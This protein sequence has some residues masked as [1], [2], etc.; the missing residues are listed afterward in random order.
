MNSSPK[1]NTFLGVFTPS[2]LTILGVILYLRVGWVVGNAGLLP[3]LAIIGLANIISLVT[4]LSVSAVSTNMSVG[5]GGAYYIVSRSLG[6]EIG[7]AIGI[8]LYLSQV[9]SVTLYSFGFAES[10]RIL[11]PELPI[12]IVAAIVVLAVTL[13]SVK[14]AELSLK[15]QIPVMVFIALSFISLFAGA[16]FEVGSAVLWGGYETGI[17]FWTVFAVFFPAVTGILVGVSMSGD[18]KNPQKSIPAGTLLAVI[19]GF[20]FYL[21]VP[22]ALAFSADKTTLLEDS[23]VWTKVAIVPF[24]VLPGLWGAIFSSAVGSILAAPRTLQALA[25]DRVRSLFFFKISA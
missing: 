2:I 20:I 7:G 17:D 24:L 12:E 10:L 5:V 9:L 23:L 4:A 8:P 1:L 25:N 19:T 16:N 22:V 18:L 21:A 6:L 14:G 3:A 15:M 11:F 13:I